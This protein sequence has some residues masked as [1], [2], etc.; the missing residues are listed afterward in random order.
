MY[1][2]SPTT[3]EAA[4]TLVS[5]LRDP[6]LFLCSVSPRPPSEASTLQLFYVTAG[7]KTQGQLDC[8]VS[9]PRAWCSVKCERRLPGERTVAHRPPHAA[10]GCGLSSSRQTLWYAADEQ[11]RLA[12]KRRRGVSTLGACGRLTQPALETTSAGFCPSQLNLQVRVEV[13]LGTFSE[14]PN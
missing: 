4:E 7:V 5:F 14:S 13:R 12:D 2:N 8:Q 3:E 1:P 6:E 9:R 11:R 10:L